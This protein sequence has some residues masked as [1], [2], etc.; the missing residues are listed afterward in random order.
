MAIK[1]IIVEDNT[2]VHTERQLTTTPTELG[3]VAGV[4]GPIQ[5]QVDFLK[6]GHPYSQWVVGT[7]S[8]TNL[9]TNGDFE[10]DAIGWNAFG[11]GTTSWETQTP[12]VG[13]GS[14]KIT[15][16]ANGSMYANIPFHASIVG[17]TYRIEALVKTSVARNVSMNEDYSTPSSTSS[18]SCETT[19]KIVYT[20]VATRTSISPYI[21]VVSCLTGDTALVDSV[22]FYDLTA[23]Y[24]RNLL[25][26]NQ[27]NAETDTT[28]MTGSIGTLTR[29]TTTPIAGTGDFKLVSTGSNDLQ[30]TTDG[31]PI[32]V[33]P[34][35]WYVAQALTKTAGMATS[36]QMNLRIRWI[37]ASGSSISY[38]SSTTIS[39]TTQTIFLSVVGQAPSLAVTASVYVV[40][41]AAVSGET[42]YA[43]SLMFELLDTTISGKTMWFTDVPATAISAGLPGQVALGTDGYA[44][45]CTAA[46]VWK[47]AALVSW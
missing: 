19:T 42:L 41:I 23:M 35:Q 34:G 25:T 13:V 4:T 24:G 46:N 10:A 31:T 1:S 22:V 11:N 5:S 32:S 39:C 47:R 44:Y 18:F 9:V 33:I 7:G 16:T 20:F 6:K 43:D 45:F 8:P 26:P 38:T 30:I 15:C 3:Y 12:L 21:S 14:L 40:V 27:S 29:N 2:G 37:D 36:R 28:G 17:H